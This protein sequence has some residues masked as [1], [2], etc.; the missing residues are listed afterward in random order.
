MWWVMVVVMAST[1]GEAFLK[2]QRKNDNEQLF[3]FVT[4]KINDW[5]WKK[6]AQTKQRGF[7]FPNKI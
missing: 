7:L 6:E 3:T 1:S 5:K 4:L 2:G